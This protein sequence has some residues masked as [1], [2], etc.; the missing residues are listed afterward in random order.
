VTGY[1]HP[2]GYRILPEDRDWDARGLGGMAAEPKRTWTVK[3]RL[4]SKIVEAGF[5]RLGEARDWCDEHPLSAWTD[6]G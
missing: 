4:S 2:N 6:G 5:H 1:L 3:K